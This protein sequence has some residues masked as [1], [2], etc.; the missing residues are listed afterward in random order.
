[1]VCIELLISNVY[2]TERIVR[3]TPESG[4]FSMADETKPSPEGTYEHAKSILIV[5][6]DED[7]GTFLVAAL[8]QETL[9]H[10]ILVPDGFAALKTVHNLKPDLVIL[11]YQLPHMTGIEV[12]DQLRARPELADVPA[13]LMTAGLGM[14]RHALEKRKLVGL[15]K[16]LE[17]ASF[18]RAYPT[19]E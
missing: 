3:T 15:S 8:Q 4:S 10:P 11:D 13:I 18:L 14:P 6:D 16:P 12:Y 2:S 5:E 19:R 17:L 1:M 7:I 9:Y